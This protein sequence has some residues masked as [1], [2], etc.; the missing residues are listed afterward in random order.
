VDR[1]YG[2]VSPQREPL[3]NDRWLDEGVAVDDCVM[4]ELEEARRIVAR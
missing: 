1:R 3:V 2:V 4:G